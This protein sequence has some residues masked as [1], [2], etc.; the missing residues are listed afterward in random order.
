MFGQ[1]GDSLEN[2]ERYGDSIIIY[3]L[4]TLI[5]SA[6]ISES[7]ETAI[8]QLV[9]ERDD[10]SSFQLSETSYIPY[11][12]GAAGNRPKKLEPGTEEYYSVLSKLVIQ[13]FEPTDEQ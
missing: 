2:I 6:F 11:L 3:N 12:S 9:F 5:N 13:I 10:N 4:G 8:V 7:S 1:G